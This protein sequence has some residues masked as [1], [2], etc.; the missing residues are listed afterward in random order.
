MLCHRRFGSNQINQIQPRT[1]HVCNHFLK[2][3]WISFLKQKTL[4]KPIKGEDPCIVDAVTEGLLPLLRLESRNNET[5]Q[6]LTLRTSEASL[7]SNG[8]SNSTPT[9][10]TASANAST[11]SLP[12]LQLEQNYTQA[13]SEI[14]AAL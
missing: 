3:N 4:S 13:L 9:I 7:N 12:F 2:Q 14:V 8:L 10:S 5:V 6:F 1:W 11:A